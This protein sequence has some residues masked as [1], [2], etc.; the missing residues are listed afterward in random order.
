MIFEL[1]NCVNVQDKKKRNQNERE[2][3]S[4]GEG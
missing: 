4:V 2:E 3:G 1:V